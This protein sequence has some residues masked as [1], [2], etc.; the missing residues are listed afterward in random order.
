VLD[1]H[2]AQRASAKGLLSVVFA[3]HAGGDYRETILD[4]PF[5]D[6]FGVRWALAGICFKRSGH[7]GFGG[8][9]RHVPLL[10]SLL[11]EMVAEG[12]LETDGYGWRQAP[13]R[14]VTP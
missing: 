8:D 13:P 5:L 7:Y 9:D 1:L 12:L 6:M 4:Q 11:G 3:Q 14:E 10:E 2:K